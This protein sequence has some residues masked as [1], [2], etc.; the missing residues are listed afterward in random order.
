MICHKQN[1]QPKQ[2]AWSC[3]SFASTTFCKGLYTLWN[4]ISY[5]K[6]KECK[7]IQVDPSL[8]TLNLSQEFKLWFYHGLLNLPWL[9]EF[10]VAC[11]ISHKL[12]YRGFSCKRV[13]SICTEKYKVRGRVLQVEL[14]DGCTVRPGDL[15]LQTVNIPFFISFII[16]IR[17]D[18]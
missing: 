12:F 11:W 5:C 2:T 17:L 1:T 18:G 8:D 16:I 10:A 7:K 13:S 6:L 15:Y 14:R 9:V 3:F 4:Y